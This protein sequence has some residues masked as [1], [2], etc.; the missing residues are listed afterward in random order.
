MAG[1]GAGQTDARRL[2]PLIASQPWRAAAPEGSLADMAA[3][4]GRLRE[5][6]PDAYETTT[7]VVAPIAERLMRQAL[8]EE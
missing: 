4:Q 5:R 7:G 8:V 6:Y 1:R 3:V 2:E